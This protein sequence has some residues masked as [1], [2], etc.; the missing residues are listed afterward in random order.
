MAFTYSCT[1]AIGLLL[2]F[3]VVAMV[4]IEK[5]TELS[6]FVLEMKRLNFGVIQFRVCSSVSV[7]KR[8][9]RE[10]VPLSLSRRAFML[11]L[12]YKLWE[13]IVAST[14]EGR[15]VR[16]PGPLQ[17]RRCLPH[18]GSVWWGR[19]GGTGVQVHWKGSYHSSD[20]RR[21]IVQERTFSVARR[22]TKNS[23]IIAGCVSEVIQSMEG[24]CSQ[25]RHMHDWH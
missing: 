22:S 6:D 17:A 13:S 5:I 12:V 16:A 4:G 10:P 21:E 2:V 1:L 3:F 18:G 9:R 11:A 15:L 23:R 7:K 25:V 24:H 20:S 8:Q 19:R 14:D